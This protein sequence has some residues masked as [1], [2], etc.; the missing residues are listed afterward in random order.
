[1]E[2]I[3]A[4]RKDQVKDETGVSEGTTE[5]KDE[6][7]SRDIDPAA[8][9]RDLPGQDPGATYQPQQWSGK[10]GKRA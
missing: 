3:V 2:L 4:I 10:I 5:T 6:D 9:K 8:M 1:V 7:T